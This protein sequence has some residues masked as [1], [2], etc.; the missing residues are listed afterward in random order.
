[1]Q[2]Q[3]THASKDDRKSEGGSPPLARVRTTWR[4]LNRWHSGIGLR[5][6]VRVLLFSSAITLLLTLLQLYFDYRRDVGT[7]DRQISEIEGSYR[8]SLGEGLW[9]L[10][11][12][13]LELQVDGILQLPDIRFVEVREATDRADPMVVTAGSHQANADVHREFPIVHMNRGAEQTLGVLSIEATFDDV[14]RRLFDTAIVILISQGAKTFVVSFFI[15]YIVNWL[16]TRHLVT[17]AMFL[18]GYDLRRSPPPLRLERRALQ[19]VDELDQ[20]V[21]AFNG[22]CLENSR[23]YRDLADREGKIRRLVD[24]NIVGIVFWDLEGGIRDANDAFLHMVGYEHADLVSGRL[25]WTDIT[26]A[27]WRERDERA[28]AELNS[29]GT[30]QPFEKEYFRKD[31][32]RVPVLIGGALFQEGGNEGVAFVLDLSE[33]KRAEEALRSSEAYLAEAQTLSRTGSWAWSPDQDIRYW[34]EECYRVLSF[35][36]QDGLPRFEQFFQRIHPDDQ[37]GFRELIQTAIR[38]KAEWKADYRI[39][40]PGGAVRDIHVVGHPVL[41]TSGHLDEFVGTVIDVTEPKRAEQELRTS[42]LERARAE[43]ALR[44]AREKFAQASKI[45]SLA[46]LSA[47]IAHEINQ[48]LQAIVANGEA[49][50]RWLDATPPNI[51]K[52]IRTAQRVVRDGY[53]AAEVVS[54]IRALFKHAAPAKVDLDINQLIVQVRTLMADEIQGNGVSLETELG[55]DLP[56]IRADAVQIQQIIVNLVRNA[57]EAMAG[58]QRKPLLIR[59]R[60]SEGHVTVDVRDQGTGLVDPEKIFEPFVSTKKTGMGMGLTICRSIIEAHAGDIRV[61]HNEGPGVT[62]SFSLPLNAS[63]AT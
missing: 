47:S 10:D 58:A 37:P 16:I 51:E 29:T 22:M 52:A 5:L 33:Q 53:A 40:H 32:S 54:R 49:S 4:Y 60:R 34:S 43:Q 39:V 24:A 2:D 44:G 36:L 48:P 19:Q 25:R 23:L 12:R 59:S 17:A 21:G 63:D 28:V 56:S 35:D 3:A 15:L 42:E 55:E 26:P 27:E 50:L 14:Y 18:G 41:S 13:Q 57:I 6:L 20:L 31:G 7:I 11:A 46:E 1:M 45:A 62:F 9:N 30:F 8:R 61:V 38:E